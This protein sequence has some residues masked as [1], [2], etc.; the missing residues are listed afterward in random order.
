[1]S[2]FGGGSCVIQIESFSPFVNNKRKGGEGKT[3]SGVQKEKV[4]RIFI[5][6]I[7]NHIEYLYLTSLSA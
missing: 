2:F 1:M 6:Y 4:L 7:I 5:D 3:L